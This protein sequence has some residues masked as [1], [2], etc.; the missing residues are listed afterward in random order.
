MLLVLVGCASDAPPATDVDPQAVSDAN[1]TNSA[2]STA[3]RQ[4]LARARGRDWIDLGAHEVEAYL[5]P[6]ADS[7]SVLAIW[8]PSTGA[9]GLRNLQAELSGL[10]TLGVRTAIATMSSGSIDPAEERV[11]LR[12]SQI[13]MAAYRI[14]AAAT[15][16]NFEAS[17]LLSG[18]LVLQKPGEKAARIFPQADRADTYRNW[19][20]EQLEN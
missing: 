19:V 14:P 9:A 13:Y 1:P 20:L 6:R 2:L 5:S 10:D 3:E 12:E 17:A 15:F 16:E 18:G 7:S 8:R 11:A 4:L